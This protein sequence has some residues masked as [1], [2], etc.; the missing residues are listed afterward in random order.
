MPENSGEFSYNHRTVD[1]ENIKTASEIATLTAPVAAAVIPFTGMVKRMLGPAADEVGEM[2][3]DRV[4]LYRYGRQMKCLE[5]AEKM[6]ADAGFTPQ[7]VPPKILF[8]LLEGASFEE[9]ETL[10]DM[11]AALLA[12]ASTRNGSGVRPAFI[13][14]LRNM[15]P[16]EATLLWT[17]PHLASEFKRI[18][19]EKGYDAYRIVGLDVRTPVSKES[20][21]EAMKVKEETIGRIRTSLPRFA[22]EEES[23]E[24]A[25]FELCVVSLEAAKLVGIR[26]SWSPKP[27][28]EYLELTPLGEAFLSACSQTFASV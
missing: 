5:K 4:R 22:G 3:R 15:A 28:L 12:N 20:Y 18:L 10:H 6:A 25:R 21:D 17:I 7:P 27:L 19:I 24:Q 1:P 8:P 26:G 16:D 2:L 14:I 11:W 23:A 13:A 9:D